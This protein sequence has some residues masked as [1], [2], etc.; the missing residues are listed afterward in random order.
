MQ[1][2]RY[3]SVPTYGDD[4]VGVAR[5]QVTHPLLDEYATHTPQQPHP[6]HHTPLRRQLRPKPSPRPCNLDGFKLLDASAVEFPDEAYTCDVSNMNITSVVEED[7]TYFT[8][9]CEPTCTFMRARA[10]V[11]MCNPN[12]TPE[13]RTFPHAHLT[14]PT[15]P[16]TFSCPGSMQVATSLR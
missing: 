1:Q 5:N 10:R 2:Q 12:A 13:A 14:P 3:L 7:L 16:S 11:Y 8:K 15:P 6:P 4:E 9:V